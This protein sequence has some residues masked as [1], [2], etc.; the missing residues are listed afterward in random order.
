MTLLCGR[1]CLKAPPS[2]RHSGEA[3][4]STTATAKQTQRQRDRR[5]GLKG[6][7]WSHKSASSAPHCRCTRGIC[8]GGAAA[9]RSRC[10]RRWRSPPLGVRIRTASGQCGCS[11]LCPSSTLDLIF[12]SKHNFISVKYSSKI[13]GVFIYKPVSSTVLLTASP[14]PPPPASSPLPWTPGGQT[15]CPLRPGCTVGGI[16]GDAFLPLSL[17]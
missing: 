15:A 11:F 4:L 16:P 13:G 6:A 5:A 7:H 12:Y 9:R 14:A 3:V 2:H 10:F 17:E 1:S 8:A